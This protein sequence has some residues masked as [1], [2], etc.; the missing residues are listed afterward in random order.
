MPTCRPQPHSPSP[1]TNLGHWHGSWPISDVISTSSSYSSHLIHWTPDIF[2]HIPT[3]HFQPTISL[4]NYTRH[5]FST[6]TTFTVDNF[7]YTA[8][9][10]YW[11]GIAH[12]KYSEYVIREHRYSVVLWSFGLKT[13]SNPNNITTP[14]VA[15]SSNKPYQ[16]QE[17]DNL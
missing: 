14:S 15:I 7:I 4:S 9:S 10:T 13:Y 8:S 16:H 12:Q 2:L 17:E 1:F 3:H 11:S 5:C 6:N